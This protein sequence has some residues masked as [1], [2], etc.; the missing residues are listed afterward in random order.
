MA[1]TTYLIGRHKIKN[2]Q[3][4]QAEFENVGDNLKQ[5]GVTKAWVNRNLDDPNE[6]IVVLQCSDVE[7]CRQWTQSNEYRECTQKAGCIGT[8][9]LTFVEELS[10]V[11]EPSIR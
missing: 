3:Q 5:I 6:I 10:R 7:K 1:N 9:Q 4:F 8:A 2:L 11:P